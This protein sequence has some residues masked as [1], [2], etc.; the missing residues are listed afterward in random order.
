VARTS[1]LAT[2]GEAA[3][4]DATSFPPAAS[5]GARGGGVDSLP[6]V[7][8]RGGPGRVDRSTLRELLAYREVLWALM[9]RA[10]KI[11]YKQAT[12][13]VGWA[14]L[15]P[16]LSAAVFSLVL[17]HFAKIPRDNIDAPVFFLCGMV[18]W[19][20]FA[21][22]AGTAMESVIR[23]AALVRKV[24]FPREVLPISAIAAALVDLLPGVVILGI[25][26]A[27][28]GYT[29]GVEWVALPVVVVLLV[30]TAL[31]CGLWPAALNVYYRDV[32]LALPFFLQVGL[33]AS[34]VVYPL[35]QVPE[36]WRTGWGVVNPVVTAIDSVRRIV[37]K[38]DWPRPGMVAAA[39][40]WSLVLGLASYWGFKR[41][42]RSFADR[43]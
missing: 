38:G 4:H 20:Y 24:Y 32:R 9:V 19:T 41:M 5:P 2:A 6:V 26:A 23:D 29:P 25:V 33:F 28:Y 36:P 39:L 15:Q 1:D 35:S 42:E 37:A 17:G 34:A 13:G 31:A 11:K 16:V 21:T 30:T 40:A 18:P 7:E 43:A 8:I 22:A 10:V 14:V 27:L 3:A 12:V